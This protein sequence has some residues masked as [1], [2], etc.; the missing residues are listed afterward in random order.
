[1]DKEEQYLDIYSFRKINSWVEIAK[2]VGMSSPEAAEKKY[3]TID[4]YI[5]EQIGL[6]LDDTV[7]LGK[8]LAPRIA[9]IQYVYESR[10]YNNEERKK[11]FGEFKKFYQWY[12]KQPRKCFYCRT[13]EDVTADLFKKKILSSK[14]GSWT[15]GLEVERKDGLTY[16][17]GN[18]VLACPLCNNAKSDLISS[19]DFKNYIASGIRKYQGAKYR[20]DQRSAL[21]NGLLN[22]GK[23]IWPRKRA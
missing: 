4:G 22:W 1:M 21:I 23:S 10:F 7:E 11:G 16:N 17:E 6:N 9:E 15:G 2:A 18:C 19:D 5:S 14:K 13:S 20:K 3:K 8:K 12:K